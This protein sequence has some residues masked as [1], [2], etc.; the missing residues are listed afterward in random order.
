MTEFAIAIVVLISIIVFLKIR[1]KKLAIAPTE[2]VKPS[3][4]ESQA[5][6]KTVS[7]AKPSV[8]QAN[9]TSTTVAEPLVPQQVQQAVE[10]NKPAV[11]Q[12]QA[13]PSVAVS[14]PVPAKNLPQ[15]SMLR[16]HYLTH[17]HAMVS[18][19]TPRP[20]DSALRR[21]YDAHIAAKIEQSLNSET[22]LQQLIQDYKNNQKAVANSVSK[23]E[24][25]TVIV[26]APETTPVQETVLAPIIMK[27][28]SVSKIPEDSTLKRHYF[29]QLRAQA[30]A[31]LPARPTDSTLRRHYDTI[32]EN[33][34]EK[35]LHN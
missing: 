3:K 5:S 23:V 34:I 25:Q 35:Q 12:T 11:T 31:K 20:T 29:T 27:Q 19:I 15:D 2:P 17:L 13:S 16:R 26:S 10:P 22:A 33:E 18:S 1:K 8:L 28:A 24:P 9:E 14:S 21:H 4:P 6:D 32:L 30:T 7:S